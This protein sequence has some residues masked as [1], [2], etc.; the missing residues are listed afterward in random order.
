[1]A[2]ITG[3]PA[4]ID[5][6]RVPDDRVRGYGLQS[7]AF[8]T[9]ETSPSEN[10]SP[11]DRLSMRGVT[12]EVNNCGRLNCWSHDCDHTGDKF[13]DQ[14]G[15][16][17]VEAASFS[18]VATGPRCFGT[19]AIA[20]AERRARE[21]IEALEWAAVEYAVMTGSCGAS[22]FL[23]GPPT[24]EGGMDLTIRPDPVDPT[25]Y[26]AL[27]EWSV[28]DLSSAPV[29]PVGTDPVAPK[30]ALAALEWGMRDYG[31]PGVIHAPSWV[32]PWFE[33]WERREASRLVTQLG[34]GW[35][36]G[37]GYVSV[38]PGTAPAEMPTLDDTPDFASAWLYG[39]GAVRVWRGPITITPDEARYDYRRNRSLVLAERAYTVSIQCPYVAVNV[40]LTA[41]P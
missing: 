19:H 40:D 5:P 30:T 2:A 12:H 20:N 33:D 32:Y 14:H 26:T 34:H 17:W 39:T 13:A 23:A 41:T 11:G 28:A 37:R 38:A 31:G 21:R 10:L 35:A 3:P 6:S 22:P 16:E 24:G 27:A 7:Q 1:M 25:G 4:L 36:F 9:E 8:L 29:L 15:Q 18:I